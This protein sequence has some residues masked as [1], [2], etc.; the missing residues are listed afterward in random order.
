[1]NN[2][3]NARK[4]HPDLSIPEIA[5]GLARFESAN[6]MDFPPACSLSCRDWSKISRGT[7]HL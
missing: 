5:P 3:K 7:N 2:R 1:M 4:N 6:I